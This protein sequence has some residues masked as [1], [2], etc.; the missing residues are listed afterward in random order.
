MVASN[1]LLSFLLN[2]L[3]ILLNLHVLSSGK[4]AKTGI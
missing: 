2:W 3:Q 4:E 1:E